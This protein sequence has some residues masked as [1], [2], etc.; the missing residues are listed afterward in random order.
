MLIRQKKTH[1]QAANR[2]SDNFGTIFIGFVVNLFTQFTGINPYKN[3]VMKTFGI[4]KQVAILAL[5]SV[6][7]LSG[8]TS[9]TM[10]QT[11]PTGAKVYLNDEFSGETPFALSDTKIIGA[12]T[13]IRLE[14]SGYKSF[15]TFIQRSEEIDAGPVVCGFLFTPVWWLW[16]MKYKPAHTY[17]LVPA[18]Q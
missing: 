9:M 2:I 1:R 4:F 13:S 17:E 18:G 7:F 14:K 8:C 12:T 10:I 16:A 11:V 5:A 15:T 3:I 6:L